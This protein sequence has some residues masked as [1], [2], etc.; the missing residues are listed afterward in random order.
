MQKT[1]WNKPN[2]TNIW[3]KKVKKIST[4]DKTKPDKDRVRQFTP[5]QTT[6]IIQQKV[7]ALKT[8]TQALPVSITHKTTT[9]HN[10]SVILQ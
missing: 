3:V 9:T 2:E 8:K 4:Y 1:W 6:Y 10:I 7:Q 5:L